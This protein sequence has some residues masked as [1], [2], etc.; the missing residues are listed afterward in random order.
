MRG[1]T[2]SDIL[3]WL[4]A[5]MFY[6]GSIYSG[7]KALSHLP[8]PVFLLSHGA[9]DVVLILCDRFFPSGAIHLSMPL[10]M[11][12]MFLALWSAHY[13]STMIDLTWIILSTVFSG[14]YRSASFWYTTPHWPYSSLTI[15]QRQYL[16]NLL[17]VV[18]L[19]PV[20]VLLGH[21]HQIKNNFEYLGEIRFY[22]GCI[23]S[24]LLG[25]ASNFMWGK[26]NFS[27]PLAYLNMLQLAGKVLTI[28]LSFHLFPVTHTMPLWIGIFLGILGDICLIIGNMIERNTDY[29]HEISDVLVGA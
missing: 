18:T 25:W 6:V 1:V 9:S 13:D 19:F 10:K 28:L 5:M 7:S 23:S 21:H 4:P 24:G 14:A 11:A 29:N 22:I 12:G 8:V 2:I 17:G 27:K 20:A 16:N 26:L 3:P 15:I